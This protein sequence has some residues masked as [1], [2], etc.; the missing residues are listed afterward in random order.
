MGMKKFFVLFIAGAALFSCSKKVKHDAGSSDWK[1]L[2]A[3][4][5]IIADVYH[6]MKESGNLAPAKQLMSQLADEAE[7]WS[8]STLPD[9]VNTPKM[10][11]NLQKLKID[12]RVLADN[13]SKGASD[14]VVKDQ[15]TKLHDQFHGIMKAW[16]NENEK[17][18]E[19]DGDH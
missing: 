8:A 7:K 6:P 13:V 15:L 19:G 3:F 10:K 4:H 12:A 17:H 1:E 11:E 9:K 14:D 5:K 2:E 18:D 16:Y